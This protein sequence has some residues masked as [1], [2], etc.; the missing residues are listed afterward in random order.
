MTPEEEA[1]WAAVDAKDLAEIEWAEAELSRRL[2]AVDSEPVGGTATWPAP[3]FTKEEWLSRAEHERLLHEL[4]VRLSEARGWTQV[5][6]DELAEHTN[7]F[8]RYT[9][10]LPDWLR[11]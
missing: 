11:R 7:R 8:A 2:A 4:R 6:Y 5:F 1:Y 9:L 3:P 10:T